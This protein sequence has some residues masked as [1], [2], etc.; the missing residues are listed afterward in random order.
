VDD[1]LAVQEV[2]SL[3]HLAAY[4]LNLGLSEASIQ[5]WK[6]GAPLSLTSPRGAST[7]LLPDLHQTFSRPAMG[8]I[9]GSL[10]AYRPILI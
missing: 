6:R 10:L 9:F 5:L 2:E 3:Q 1:P 4:D 8:S 7:W